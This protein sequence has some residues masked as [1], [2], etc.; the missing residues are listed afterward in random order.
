MELGNHLLQ[1]PHLV[2]EGNVAHS[3]FSDLIMETKIGAGGG[4]LCTIV[5]V[6]CAYKV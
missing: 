2:P 5:I 3:N 1:A 4:S 6:L